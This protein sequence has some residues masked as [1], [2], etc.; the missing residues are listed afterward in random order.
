MSKKPIQARPYQLIEFKME[1]APVADGAF[2]I[3]VILKDPRMTGVIF[4]F[5][6][7]V[8]QNELTDEGEIPIECQ[9]NYYILRHKDSID[10]LPDDETMIELQKKVLSNVIRDLFRDAVAEI[11]ALQQAQKVV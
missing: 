3:K 4:E 7:M 11:E 10:E 2:L 5:R 6:Q 9:P 1:E 8:V